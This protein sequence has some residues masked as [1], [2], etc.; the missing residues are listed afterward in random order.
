LLAVRFP[1]YIKKHSLNEL[2]PK[3]WTQFFE[4]QFK[5]ESAFI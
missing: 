2:H 1:T 5:I 4:V 3:N